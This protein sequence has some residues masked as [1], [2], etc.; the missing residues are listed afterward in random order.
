M[1]LP[2]TPALVLTLL[3]AC[4]GSR[5]PEPPAAPAAAAEAPA[6]APATAAPVAAR[7]RDPEPAPAGDEV[8]ASA[9]RPVLARTCAPCHEKGGR[10]YDRLPFD[11]ATVVASHAEPVLRRLKEPKDKE[12]VE[13]WLAG[14]ADRR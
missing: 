6:T 10:M 4:A 12:A 13:A 1:R 3:A 2:S 8:F 7:E 5:R 9:V 11:D 14:R